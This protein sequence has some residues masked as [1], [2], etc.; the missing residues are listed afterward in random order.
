MEENKRLILV[1]ELFHAALALDPN[2]RTAF[3]DNSCA[4]DPGLRAEVLNLISLHEKP[5]DFL[6]SPAYEG[7]LPEEPQESSL[8]GRSLGHYQILDCIGTG[9]MGKVYRA[10]D[11][12]LDR[13]VAI[14][15]LHSESNGRPRE[16]A[17]LRAGSQG[18][19]CSE[20]PG[21]CD[22]PRHRPVRGDRFHRDGI[23]NGQDA[24]PVD[25]AQSP[26]DQRG[27]EV[28]RTDRRCARSGARCRHQFTAI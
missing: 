1:E 21:Y 2:Q 28:R 27:S 24:Q 19:L 23:H 26:A 5:G 18:C 6:N 11:T 4:S 22:D 16:K 17:T 25:P 8:T 3:L 10:R 12:R 14:K 13:S 15:V 20:S 7:S 9:G